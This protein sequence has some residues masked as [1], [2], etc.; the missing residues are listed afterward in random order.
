MIIM[1]KCTEVNSKIFYWN[2]RE[3][4]LKLNDRKKYNKKIIITNGGN[5]GEELIKKSKTNN[6]GRNYSFSILLFTKKSY[7][8]GI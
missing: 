2:T 8:L 4:A 5:K 7:K 6:R 1:E 3:D